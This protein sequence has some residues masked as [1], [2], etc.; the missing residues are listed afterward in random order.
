MHVAWWGQNLDFPVGGGVQQ[1]WWGHGFVTLN[2]G[3]L[4]ATHIHSFQV[5]GS[6]EAVPTNLTNMF[7]ILIICYNIQEYVKIKNTQHRLNSIKIDRIDL[8]F[9]NRYGQSTWFENYEN[10]LNSFPFWFIC[11]IN[12]ILCFFT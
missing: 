7:W 1:P 6:V 8:I 3:N 2:S 11:L 4:R 5:V 10:W 9:N 12:N